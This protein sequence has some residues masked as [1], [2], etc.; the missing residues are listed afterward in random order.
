MN[1][2]TQ[3]DRPLRDFSLWLA[4]VGS[5]TIWLIQFQTIY[6]L[7]FPACGSHHN[8]VINATCAGFFICIAVIAIMA[9]RN[10]S[11]APTGE[12]AGRTRRFMAITG[13]MVSALF[14]LVVG[15]QW[16]AAVMIDPCPI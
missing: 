12:P 8:A 3:T 6:M 7:V 2:T 9:W 4:I 13:V 16:I 14:L 10:W 5:P 11:D 15:A 1:E